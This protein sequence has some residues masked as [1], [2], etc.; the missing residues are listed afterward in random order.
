MVRFARCYTSGFFYF[1]SKNLQITSKLLTQGYRYRKLRKHLESSSG[2]TLSF[3]L[4]LVKYRSKNI[5]LAEFLT[6][7]VYK[8]MSVKCDANFVSSGSKIVERLRRRKYDAVIIE[9]TI[10]LLLIPYTALYRSFQQGDG[11]YMTGLVQIP[12]E[13][14]RPWSSSPLIDNRDTFRTLTGVRF[15][16]GGA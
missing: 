5:F 11:Y 10:C 2:Q 9:K 14:T 1:H 3:Y 6:R 8:L 7:V 4:N 16:T 15:K 13:E 12:S